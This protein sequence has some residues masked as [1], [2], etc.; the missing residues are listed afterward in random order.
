MKKEIEIIIT[1]LYKPKTFQRRLSLWQFRFIVMIGIVLLL[2]GGLGLFLLHYTNQQNMSIHYLI[3]DNLRLEQENKKVTELQNRL[4]FLEAERAK[5]A[6][7]LGAD[8]NPPPLKL[9]DLQE[10]YKPYEKP[11]II[12]STSRFQS[13]PTTGY[14][15]SRGFSKA[16]EAVDFAAPLGMPVFAV[17]SGVV[18]DV[19]NDTFYGNYILLD[20]GDNYQAFY[21][22]LYKTIKSAQAN[23]AAGEIIGYVGTSG[24][25]TAPHLHLEIWRIKDGKKIRLDPQKELQAVLKPR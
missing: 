14:I 17:G 20:L 7:M 4:N 11:E 12:T 2:L 8:K 18:K 16:H 25:S 19:G 6:I 5:I 10:E 24:R 21:G 15:I 13:A 1:S 9:E 3:E 22:H 23:V